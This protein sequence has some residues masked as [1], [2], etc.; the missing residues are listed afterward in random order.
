MFDSGLNKDMSEFGKIM[1][2]L[3]PKINGQADGSRVSSILKEFLSE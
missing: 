3:M 2:D 1:K